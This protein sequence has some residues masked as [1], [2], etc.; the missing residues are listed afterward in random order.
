MLRRAAK[1]SQAMS[2]YELLI[3]THGRATNEPIHDPTYP[4]T[5][6]S[7]DDLLDV[8]GLAFFF[9]TTLKFIN[10][11]KDAVLSLVSDNK[12]LQ[13]LPY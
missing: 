4:Q 11:R 3:G 9:T 8:M 13:I 2:Q 12:L 5:E 6:G 10:K 7:L 1:R